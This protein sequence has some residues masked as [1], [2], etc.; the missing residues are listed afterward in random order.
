MS[1]GG[2]ESVRSVLYKQLRDGSVDILSFRCRFLNY[3][4]FQMS[5]DSNWW[6]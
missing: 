5:T 1:G 6:V 4:I 2:Q 3:C